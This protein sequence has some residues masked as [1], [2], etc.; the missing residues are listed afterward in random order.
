MQRTFLIDPRAVTTDA[1]QQRP[2]VAVTQEQ[3]QAPPQLR[4]GG[5]FLISGFAFGVLVGETLFGAAFPA[6]LVGLLAGMVVEFLSAR[7]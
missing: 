3:D 6:A 1:L 7:S 5:L 2:S 4:V